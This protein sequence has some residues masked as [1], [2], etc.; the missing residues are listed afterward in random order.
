MCTN[1]A[2]RIVDD[3]D[4]AGKF[5]AERGCR[6]LCQIFKRCLQLCVEREAMELLLGR[7][8]HLLQN[9]HVRRAYLGPLAAREYFVP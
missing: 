4:C 5:W 3:E 7:A 6:F 9:P 2:V 8:A 1:C